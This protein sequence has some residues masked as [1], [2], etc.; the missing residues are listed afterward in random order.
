MLKITSIAVAAILS[1]GVANAATFTVDF[2]NFDRADVITSLDIGGIFTSVTTAEGGSTNSG[3]L[4]IFDS[5]QPGTRDDGDP[6]LGSPFTNA[7]GETSNPGNILIIGETPGADSSPGDTDS[8]PDDNGR[9]G[10]IIFTFRSPITFTGFSVFD[11]VT[12]FNVF[13]NLGSILPDVDLALE[14]DFATFVESDLNGNAVGISSLTFDFERSSGAIDGLTFEV[15]AVPLP[16]SLPL[17]FAGL[18]GLGL[19]ARRRKNAA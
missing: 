1:A 3:D 6:D 10:Q 16:A 17:L 19:V 4:V 18:G 8:N 7:A 13:S 5:T 14:N 2:E 15:A 11:N 9:G 12:D